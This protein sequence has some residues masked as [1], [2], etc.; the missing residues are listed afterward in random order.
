MKK[1]MGHWNQQ[2]KF[3]KIL[4]LEKVKDVL[5]SLIR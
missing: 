5:P 3:K 2:F 4:E 1:A